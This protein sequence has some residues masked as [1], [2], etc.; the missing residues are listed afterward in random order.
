LNLGHRQSTDRRKKLSAR[1]LWLIAMML[2]FVG[3]VAMY[4]VAY[5]AMGPRKPG[6]H[7]PVRYYRYEWLAD[8]FGPAASIESSITGE[9]VNTG[10][11]S[12]VDE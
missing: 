10:S 9:F 1:R 5:L 6:E 7:G 2:L 3:S 4:F 12:W 8:A 11:W